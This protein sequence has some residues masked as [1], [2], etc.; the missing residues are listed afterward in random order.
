MNSI[1]L[2]DKLIMNGY[3]PKENEIKLKEPLRIKTSS[4]IKFISRLVK[5]DDSIKTYL[6]KH[7]YSG[8]LAN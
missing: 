8:R 6:V 2:W 1:K 7:K 3:I 5:K 4:G